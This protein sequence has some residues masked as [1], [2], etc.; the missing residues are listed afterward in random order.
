MGAVF[1]D[2]DGTL[3]DTVPDIRDA[4]C[5]ALAD[6]G[7]PAVSD[8]ETVSYVGNGAR[9]LVERAAPRGDTEKI[10]SLFAKYYNS[11]ESAHTL[12]YAGIREMLAR[13]KARGAKLAVITNKLQPSAEKLMERFF[14]GVFDF[15]GGDDG[16][17]PCKPDPS[18]SR[19]AALTM[20]V[21][22]GESVF[23]GDGETDVATALNAGMVPVSVLWGYRKREVLEA[24]GAK[25][26][27]RDADELWQI[28]EKFL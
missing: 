19:Y 22:I 25:L 27:A 18:L 9:K 11:S 4:L 24:A 21:P 23:V 1:F 5:R 3:L 2:L 8:E 28:L 17:F 14:P 10:L 6:C 15:V 26:F 12:P 20:R 16:S 7:L 13:L